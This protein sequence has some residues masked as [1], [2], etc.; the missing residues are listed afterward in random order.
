MGTHQHGNPHTEH[1][2]MMDEW[3]AWQTVAAEFDALDLDMNDAAYTPLLRQ[4]EAWGEE[5]HK[6][7]S[8]QGP[9]VV[10]RVYTERV[11]LAESHRTERGKAKLA[12]RIA[13]T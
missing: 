7:R 10:E 5:L 9:D 4:I 3:T 11:E 8:E 13:H 6:L 12:C 2:A 1:E